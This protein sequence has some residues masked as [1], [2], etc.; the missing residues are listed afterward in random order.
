MTEEPPRTTL[1][2]LLGAFTVL[3]IIPPPDYFQNEESPSGVYIST[4]GTRRF[5]PEKVHE[6]LR[7][8]SQKD[9][10]ELASKDEH[11]FNDRNIRTREGAVLACY[12][13]DKPTGDQDEPT[14]DQDE[15]TG[16]QGKPMNCIWIN[17]ARGAQ[18]PT[19]MIPEEY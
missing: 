19:V 18:H 1:E 13:Q 11:W 15:P 7:R 4:P 2:S 3:E 14:G 16:Y 8:F 5:P 6:A 9:W 12:D 17:L 10:G